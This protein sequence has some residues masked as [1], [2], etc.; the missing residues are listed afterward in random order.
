MLV[1][2]MVDWL[3]ALNGLEKDVVPPVLMVTFQ[4]AKADTGD[5]A[6]NIVAI[7]I[8][9]GDKRRLLAPSMGVEKRVFNT[10]S[11]L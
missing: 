6:S 5:V 1:G 10:P 8:K 9:T 7:A 4:A 3:V 2:L 11:E